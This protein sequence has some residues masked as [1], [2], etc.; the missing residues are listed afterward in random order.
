MNDGKGSEGEL[1]E[2]DFGNSE[3]MSVD[4]ETK[5]PGRG[6]INDS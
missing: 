4:S 1:S 3:K 5:G 2:L 6:I